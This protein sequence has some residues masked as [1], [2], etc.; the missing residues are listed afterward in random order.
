MPKPTL[1][2]LFGAGATQTNTHVSIA[3]ADFLNLLASATNEAEDIATALIQLLA[4]NATQNQW[5]SDSERTF[6]A[7]SDNAP[8]IA[9]QGTSTGP[10]RLVYQAVISISRSL[11][12]AA[13]FADLDPDDS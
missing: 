1:T 8:Q 10:S 7:D 4:R 5:Q 9:I 3:K 12:G 11:P 6:F 13:T 2:D